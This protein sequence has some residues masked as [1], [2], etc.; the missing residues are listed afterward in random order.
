MHNKY[1]IIFLVN[2]I[3]A[4]EVIADDSTK[5]MFNT[6]NDSYK[7]TKGD[8]LKF[9]H[10]NGDVRIKTADTDHIQVTAIAQLH[11]DDPR[12]PSIKFISKKSDSN[13]KHELSIHFD[14]LDLAEQ[15]A[16]S[17]R[18]IDVGILIPKDLNLII[19][20]SDGIIDAKNIDTSS[21]F[22]SIKGKINYK[23]TGDLLAYSERG[24][25]TAQFSKT[26]KSHQVDLSTLTGDI[27]LILL[28]GANAHITTETRGPITTDFSVEI[29][30]EK[31][32]PFKKGMTKIGKGYSKITL[33]SHSGGIRIQGLTISEKE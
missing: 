14:Y 21:S 22:K 10:H 12:K 27:Q 2:L 30:R 26:K 33:K 6:L 28:E 24:K 29:N 9:N 4:V 7:V 25:V 15:E 31:K 17:K 23:G 18:R 1:I 11:A 5:W 20:T 8:T 19:N 3:L 13:N 32:S 16:W